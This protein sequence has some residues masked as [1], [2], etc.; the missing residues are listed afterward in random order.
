M[1]SVILSFLSIAMMSVCWN[2]AALLLFLNASLVPP[3]HFFTQ[4]ASTMPPVTKQRILFFSDGGSDDSYEYED[5]D[6]STAK[7][8]P[9]VK[10]PLLFGTLHL[11]QYDPC[12]EN[13]EPCTQL[14][15]KTGCLCPGY[16]GADVPPNAPI[17]NMLRPVTHGQN[18]GKVEVQWC[19]PSSV[20]SQYRVLLQ[21]SEGKS[22]E[23]QDTRRIGLVGFLAAGDRVCVEAVNAAGHSTPS[24]FSCKRY[25]P[26]DFSQHHLLWGIIGGGVALL[27][28]LIIITV[29]LKKYQLCQNSKGNSTDG[30]GNPSYNTERNL[31]SIW[32]HNRQS[33]PIAVNRPLQ[34]HA[35]DWCDHKQKQLL[36]TGLTIK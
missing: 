6:T 7:M 32:V 11:C 25:S 21:G 19:A 24:E 8:L 1:D 26:P 33:I 27:L 16:S 13:Q 3:S 15:R 9:S 2:L 14:S 12:L 35:P 20:V 28:L 17:I 31:W 23:F 29:I 18:S 5:N 22:L 34:P 4:A 10:T 36:D 30:L